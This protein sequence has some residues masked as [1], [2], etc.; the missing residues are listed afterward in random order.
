[1]SNS[2]TALLVQSTRDLC[3]Q[4]DTIIVDWA[5][6][7]KQAPKLPNTASLCIAS[8]FNLS[9]LGTVVSFIES[10]AKAPFGAPAWLAGASCLLGFPLPPLSTATCV[11]LD[12]QRPH[13][14]FDL[15]DSFDPASGFTPRMVT[16][17]GMTILNG[18]QRWLYCGWLRNPLLAPPFRSPN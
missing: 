10:K 9:C 7:T 11:V 18:E 5:R 4:K 17:K 16:Q 1:M 14:A 3:F 6:C 12:C 8:L 15:A 2:T 13:F